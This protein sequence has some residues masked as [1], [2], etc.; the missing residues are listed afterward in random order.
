MRRLLAVAWCFCGVLVFPGIFP[1][2]G[3]RGST[4]LRADVGDWSDEEYATFMGYYA[5]VSY[6]QNVAAAFSMLI[7][8]PDNSFDYDEF[9][10][11][12]S[13]FMDTTDGQTNPGGGVSTP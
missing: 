6:D 7:A 3:S 1:N 9:M 11:Y 13:E 2:V 8:P 4:Q 12:Y 10:W 5:P